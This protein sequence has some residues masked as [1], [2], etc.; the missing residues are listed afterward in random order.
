MAPREIINMDP[1]WRFHKGDVPFE[2]AYWGWL[3]AGTSYQGGSRSQLD[4]SNWR[5]VDLPHDFVVEGSFLPEDEQK[6]EKYH[7][8]PEMWPGSINDARDS[9]GSLPPDIAWYRKSFEIPSSDEGRRIYWVFDGIYRDSRVFLNDYHIGD[10]LSGYT[11]FCF[12]VTDFIRY[13]ESNLLAVRVDAREPEGWFYEGGGIYR[14]TWLIKTEPVHVRPWGDFHYA[15]VQNNGAPVSGPAP[16]VAQEQSVSARVFTRLELR[17][18][19]ENAVSCRIAVKFTGPMG[20]ET[21]AAE[22]RLELAP[23]SDKEIILEADIADPQLWSPDNP[24]LYKAVSEVYVDGV[25][26]DVLCSTFG[27]RSAVFD[28]ERG[29]ILNGREIK[30]KGMCCHQDHAGVGVAVPDSVQEYRIRRLKEMGANAYRCAHNPPAPELMDI[31]DRL[32]MLVMAENRLF[33]SGPENI[34]QLE[35]MV[36]IHRNHPSVILWSLG[37][38]EMRAQSALEGPRIAGTLKQV[39]RKLDHTRPVTLAI[40]P[41]SWFTMKPTELEPVLP[42]A[43]RLDVM[44]INYCDIHWLRFHELRPKLPLVISEDWSKGPTRGCYATEQIRCHLSYLHPRDE[45]AFYFE[46]AWELVAKHPFISGIFVWTGFDYKGEPAP[47]EW[48]A[49]ST[50]FGVMDTCGFPKDNYYYYKSQWKDEPM[51]YLFPHWNHPG[52]TGKPID[53]YCFSNCAEVELLVNE[54]SLGKKNVTPYHHIEWNAVEYQPGMLEAIGYN[55]GESAASYG[56]ETTG[57]AHAVRLLPDVTQLNGDGKDA[58][59]INVQI[60]DKED[61]VVPTASNEIL[62]GLSGAGKFLGAG[63]GNPS[64]HESDKEPRRRAFNGLCQLIVIAGSEPGAITLSAASPGLI[65]STAS[66]EVKE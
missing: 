5:Q 1:D 20:K 15:H 50:Q 23:W 49:I 51:V 3:K 57:P 41:F 66:I 35:A 12:D 59:I 17:N 30:L 4:D 46:H 58:A 2:G 63:N 56:I 9:H 33:S 11:G 65:G 52:R 61:R 16:E 14:H 28:A 44:G 25:L 37:N 54:K 22:G 32:G 18:R 36:R 45:E 42:T 34:D 10:H 27:L 13:G 21:A 53:I 7:G 47:F 43:D 19:Y 64:S 24:V 62:F 55:G 31:C 40:P 48:P 38:E 6:K 39:V 8:I 26:S 60:V 29:L